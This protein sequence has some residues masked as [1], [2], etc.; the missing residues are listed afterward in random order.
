[1]ADI[2]ACTHGVTKNVKVYGVWCHS[3]VSWQQ[4]AWGFTDSEDE[5]KFR[6]TWSD[7]V[8]QESHA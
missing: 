2:H 3:R 1:M 8:A 6:L 5:L 4:E 7:Y